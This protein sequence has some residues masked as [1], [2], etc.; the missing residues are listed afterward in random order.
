[1][2]S[3]NG[4]NL[5]NVVDSNNGIERRGGSTLDILSSVKVAILSSLGEG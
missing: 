4:V 1:M 5:K 3:N 2:K